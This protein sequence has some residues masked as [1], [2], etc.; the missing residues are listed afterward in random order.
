MPVV[1]I[2]GSV[3]EGV[4]NLYPLGVTSLFSLVPGPMTLQEAMGNGARMVADTAERV[5][6]LFVARR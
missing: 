2:V 1:A 6:R 3:G 4:D 5:M